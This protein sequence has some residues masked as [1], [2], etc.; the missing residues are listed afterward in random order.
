[1]MRLSF[2]LNVLGGIL[3]L[4]LYSC[5]TNSEDTDVS[6]PIL[7]STSSSERCFEYKG[8]G[9]R[10]YI[11]M[12]I[13][14]SS[15]TGNY[16]E[17]V[18]DDIRAEYFTKSSKFQATRQ[19]EALD[20]FLTNESGIQSRAVWYLLS[21]AN[22]LKT[23]KYRCVAVP[24]VASSDTRKEEIKETQDYI[25]L[26][27]NH[28]RG[29]VQRNKNYESNSH[30]VHGKILAYQKEKQIL[31]LVDEQKSEDGTTTTTYYFSEKRGLIAIQHIQQRPSSET[32]QEIRVEELFFKD[33]KLIA[34]L[35]KFKL[36]PV[37]QTINL[38]NMMASD[39]TENISSMLDVKSKRHTEEA[40]AVIGFLHSSKSYDEFFSH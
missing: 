5:Q 22:Q 12:N 25:Q 38:Q 33:Q 10:V 40:H 11:R 4:L 9:R 30:T 29:L 21:N 13:T 23:R 6:K 20:V 26:I 32:R 14:D 8:Q 19:E 3:G 24:C 15:V 18:R 36:H 28:L 31:K 2:F 17:F 7:I 37:E 16:K 39:I 35:E 1:M 34:V 27:N